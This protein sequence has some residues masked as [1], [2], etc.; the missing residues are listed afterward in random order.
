[1]DANTLHLR[2]NISPASVDQSRDIS[3]HKLTQCQFCHSGGATL[4]RCS[5]CK[6]Y[7]FCVRTSFLSLLSLILVDTEQIM[8]EA[9][10]ES[11]TQKGMRT[12]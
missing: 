12:H 6:I 9:S 8:P 1:M 7:V 2:F 11:R 4:Q 5:G 3:I 10:M